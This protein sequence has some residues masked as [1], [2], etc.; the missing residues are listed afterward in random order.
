MVSVTSIGLLSCGGA[1]PGERV[2]PADPTFAQARGG[3]PAVCH[4]VQADST[5]LVVDWTP[6]E[7]G[8][9][10]AAMKQGVAIFHYD[11]KTVKLLPDCKIEGSYG[12]LGITKKEQVITLDNAD[13]AQ[14][15][16]PLHGASI[17][18]SM[19]RGASLEV[20]LVMVGK[21]SALL[22]GVTSGMLTSRCEGATHYV[23]SATVGAFAMRT[24]T[25]GAARAKAAIDVFGASAE[26]KSTKGVS[27]KDGEVESC[28]SADV[29]G[30]RPPNG[31]GAP[32]RIRLLGISKEKPAEKKQDRELACPKGL[33]VVGGKC[34]E[35]PE[36]EAFECTETDTTSTCEQQCDKG[37][38]ASCDETSSRYAFGIRGA[39]KSEPKANEYIKK[40]CALNHWPSCT[41]MAGNMNDDLPKARG[42]FLKACDA[43]YIDACTGLGS[44]LSKGDDADWVKGVRAYQRGC[45]GGDTAG[46]VFAAEKLA[47]GGHGLTADVPRALALNTAVCN[48]PLGTS[49]RGEACYQAAGLL[50]KKDA[51]A[52]SF[53][54]RACDETYRDACKL[55]AK[56]K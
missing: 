52:K 35:K 30:P 25:S 41:F 43:G 48:L 17:G 29:D 8:D 10:E 22:D 55:V 36:Q 6:E 44:F 50:P 32:V 3:A 45:D 18:A 34:A 11:C 4:E 13:Q 2:R 1:T 37:N 47:T 40:A 31:C 5:P 56:M 51:R 49:W 38:A 7:R 12:F 33:V 42:I 23:Q 20:G 14:A 53:M 26:S 39:E 16:L 27:N 15:N 19:E 9:L 46:C 54:K 28:K 21:R 24:T